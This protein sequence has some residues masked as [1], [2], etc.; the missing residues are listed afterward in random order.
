MI[1]DCEDESTLSPQ[2]R[3]RPAG[4]DDPDARSSI[5]G[6]ARPVDTAC[7]EK[8]IEERL[9]KEEGRKAEEKEVR[10]EEGGV[11]SEG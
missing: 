8:E 1:G 2:P 4:S 3:S 11:R 5:F 7:R 6:S 9:R 10:R